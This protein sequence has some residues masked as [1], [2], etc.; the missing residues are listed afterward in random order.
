MSSLHVALM[1]NNRE[2]NSR[3]G[4]HRKSCQII[5]QQ[6]LAL[7]MEKDGKVHPF[8]LT[9]QLPAEICSNVTWRVSLF[10]LPSCLSKEQ[11]YESQYPSSSLRFF[12]HLQMPIMQRRHSI[13]IRLLAHKR[14]RNFL[15]G[16]RSS[17]IEPRVPM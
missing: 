5:Y 12:R 14:L 4:E 11:S 15:Y 9:P 1:P 2:G 7:E 3:R 16:I 10:P 17:I 6:K 8:A 13:V